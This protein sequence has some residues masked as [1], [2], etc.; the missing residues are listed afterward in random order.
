M[1]LDLIANSRVLRQIKKAKRTLYCTFIF[2][3]LLQLYNYSMLQ[4]A[5]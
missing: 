3:T 2:S 5:V 4:A 1:K